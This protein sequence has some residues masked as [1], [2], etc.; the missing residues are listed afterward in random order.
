MNSLRNSVRLVGNLG[1]DPEVK[2]FDSNKKMVRLSIAT[3]ESYKN[4]KGEKITDTQ[5]HNLI[6]WGTQAKLAEDLLKKGDEVAVEGKLA[7]RNYTDKDGIK[8]YVSEVVVNEFLK[9]GV[10]G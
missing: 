5:W 8:R 1:M 3:N 4:D 7:N 6:F 2:V 10:K 9:V